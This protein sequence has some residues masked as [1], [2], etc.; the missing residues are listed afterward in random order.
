M[1]SYQLGRRVSIRK[2]SGLMLIPEKISINRIRKIFARGNRSFAVDED[3][4][5]YTWG[6]NAEGQCGIESPNPIITSMKLEF[7]ENLFRMKQIS[8]GLHHTLVLLENGDVYSFG[9]TKYGQ[10][11]I[12]A[13]EENSKSPVRINLNNCKFIETRDHHSIAVNDENKVYTW[14]FGE[15]YALGNQR[16]NDE[17]L[18]FELKYKEFGDIIEVGGGSQYSVILSNYRS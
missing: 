2:P 14:G 12:G 16:E 8:A 5:L 13:S 1:D 10:L 4:M 15:T 7:F 11:G 3:G 6:Q 17:L 9:S 18:P